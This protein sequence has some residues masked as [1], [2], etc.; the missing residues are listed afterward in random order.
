MGYNTVCARKW[1]NCI[2]S[3]TYVSQRNHYGSGVEKSAIK[4]IIRRT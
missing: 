2:H 4:V 1:H 3:A